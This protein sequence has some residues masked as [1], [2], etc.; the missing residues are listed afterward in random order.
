M[1]AFFKLLNCLFDQIA[2]LV[3]CLS[4]WRQHGP[5]PGPET[6]KLYAALR[7]GIANF[8][9]AQGSNLSIG[10]RKFRHTLIIVYPV[11]RARKFFKLEIRIV[12][13]N[14]FFDS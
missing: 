6:T 11:C 14:A 3:T 2:V 9:Q 12:F 5:G 13:K 4:L 8:L 7:V 1:Y 10:R